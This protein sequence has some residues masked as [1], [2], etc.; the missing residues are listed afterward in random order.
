MK[1][2]TP[3]IYQ[4]SQY[5]AERGLDH[6]GYFVQAAAG[7]PGALIDPVALHPTDSEHITRLGGAAAVLFTSAGLGRERAEAAAGCAE[8]FGCAVRVPASDQGGATGAESRHPE[9]SLPAALTAIALPN[10]AAPDE[11]AFL[12]AGGSVFVGRGVVGAPAGQL[13]L[14]PGMAG[15]AAASAARGLRALV[16]QPVERLL[17]STG[18]PV[19]REPAA[20]LQDLLYRHDPEA[21]LLRPG[22]AIWERSTAQGVRFVRRVIEYSRPLGLRAIDFALTE[23]PPGRQNCPLHRHDGDE[24]VFLVVS[25]QGEVYTEGPAGGQRI[26]IR[27]GDVLG[28]PPR[29]QVAHALVNTGDAPLRYFA[30][31]A[32]AETL[33]M[34]DYLT[35]GARLERTPFGK[36]LRFYQPERTDVPYW[37][38]EPVDQPLPA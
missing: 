37:E 18:F 12:A 28:F 38:N 21:F 30:F 19:L 8:R 13:S 15:E 25:G 33:E 10:S 17:P 9:D 36:R 35:S 34:V 29:Y 31:G 6:N 22:E 4:W 27:A 32:P 24:E 5:D 26:P 3:L 23:V 16:A 2:I 7:E 14:P 11:T 20:A 1:Q